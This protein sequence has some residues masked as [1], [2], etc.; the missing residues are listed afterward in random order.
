MMVRE[1]LS[2]ILRPFSIRDATGAEASRVP[3]ANSK[4]IFDA[5]TRPRTPLIW[6][7]RFMIDPFSQ[8]FRGPWVNWEIPVNP[9]I[10]EFASRYRDGAGLE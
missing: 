1:L 6:G 10:R 5:T 2:S 8:V 4:S 7:R 3:L 9:L